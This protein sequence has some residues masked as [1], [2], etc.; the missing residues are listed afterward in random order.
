MT[1]TKTETVTSVTEKKKKKKK[2]K[3]FTK[4]QIEEKRANEEPSVKKKARTILENATKIMKILNGDD[5]DDG[6]FSTLH[7]IS[8][9]IEKL[10]KTAGAFP[11]HNKMLRYAKKKGL[12]QAYSKIALMMRSNVDSLTAV[13]DNLNNLT[14]TLRNTIATVKTTEQYTIAAMTKEL[15]WL[16]TNFKDVEV[17]EKRKVLGV[18]TDPVKLT[19][20]ATN[21]EYEFGPFRIELALSSVANSIDGE[22]FSCKA[23]SPRPVPGR[24]FVTHPHVKNDRPC[25]G[26]V[27]G[28]IS[29]ALSQ[30]RIGDCFDLINAVLFNYNPESPYVALHIWGAKICFACGRTV[31]VNNPAGREKIYKCSATNR[32]LCSSCV[33]ISK[34]NPENAIARSKGVTCA[35]SGYRCHPDDAFQC[36]VC[37]KNAIS[38]DFLSK[39]WT[40]K[41]V[42]SYCAPALIK[43]ENDE[44]MRKSKDSP[45]EPSKVKINKEDIFGAPFDPRNIWQDYDESLDS[46]PVVSTE[47]TETSEPAASTD[48]Q[49]WQFHNDAASAQWKSGAAIRRLMDGRKTDERPTEQTEASEP[50]ISTQ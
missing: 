3:K 36:A 44:K 2:K 34:K 20:P 30:G 4:K 33:V 6:P 41:K 38:T 13:R 50:E 22:S 40:D 37:N 9:E 24:S 1:A 18:T 5:L 46:K 32:E 39:N 45:L 10:Q 7:Q 23:I 42:C 49:T 43:K 8:T 25:T 16:T 12:R 17:D 47:Q 21:I 26:N 14:T 27:R 35:Y 15:M 19:D 31:A 11:K 29:L 48:S 28:A